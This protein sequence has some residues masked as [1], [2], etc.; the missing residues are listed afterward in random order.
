MIEVCCEYLSVRWIWHC[1]YVTCTFYSESILC[2]FL[3]VKERLARTRRDIWE[4]SD[5]N[6]SWTHNH[7]V[8]KWTLDH[9]PKL[10]KSLSCVLSTYLYGA[11]N[12]MFLSCHLRVLEWIHT[13][14][15]CKCQ[16]TLCSKHA[17]YL[18][19]KWLQRYSNPQ[20]PS[21]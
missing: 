1:F 5:C 2:S 18:K 14:Q 6:R 15:L 13:L 8:R 3:N 4:L 12:C 21:S 11:F 9:L 10:A 17:R 19:F 7:L 20:P 16:G